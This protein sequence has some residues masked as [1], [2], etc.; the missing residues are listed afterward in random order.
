MDLILSYLI[1]IADRAIELKDE[2][3][4]EILKDMHVL[5]EEG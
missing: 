5:K 3:L 4:L 1:K 2:E